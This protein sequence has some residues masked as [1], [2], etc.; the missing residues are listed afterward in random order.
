MIYHGVATSRSEE[1]RNEPIHR[2]LLSYFHPIFNHI[3]AYRRTSDE[4]IAPSSS[5]MSFGT[6]FTKRTQ[7]FQTPNPNLTYVFKEMEPFPPCHRQSDLS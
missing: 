5:H 2:P 7:A 4:P 1:I 6:K 3:Q